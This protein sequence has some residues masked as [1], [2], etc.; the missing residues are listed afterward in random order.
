MNAKEKTTTHDDSPLGNK[1][2]RLKTTVA[3]R[4]NWEDVEK[5]IKSLEPKARSMYQDAKSWVQTNPGKAIAIGVASAFILGPKRIGK[6]ARLGMSSGALAILHKY[7]KSSS[8]G[9]AQTTH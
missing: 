8:D 1:K 3:E 7:L 4:L 5:D 6:I 2:G 9:S